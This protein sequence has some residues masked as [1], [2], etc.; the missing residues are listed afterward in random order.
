MAFVRPRCCLGYALYHL[1]PEELVLEGYEWL[2]CLYA[3]NFP[4]CNIYYCCWRSHAIGYHLLMPCRWP[5]G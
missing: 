2:K 4:M 1:N 5:S 3:F